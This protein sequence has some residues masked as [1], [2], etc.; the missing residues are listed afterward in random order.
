[1]MN[2][3]CGRVWTHWQMLKLR[4]PVC[5]F[6][7]HLCKASQKCCPKERP[8]KGKYFWSTSYMVGTLHVFITPYWAL[9]R[10]WYYHC[11]YTRGNS[12]MK[13]GSWVTQPLTE[14]TWWSWHSN[15]SWAE[16][17]E[18]GRGSGVPWLAVHRSEF[19]IQWQY[20]ES[21]LT[22]CTSFIRWR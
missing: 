6:L 18:Q 1:M 17:G 7:S 22:L 5:R 20:F 21:F 2:M 16:M 15:T 4:L 14:A 12:R 8:G 13:E 3:K 9:P 10:G 19:E 11:V